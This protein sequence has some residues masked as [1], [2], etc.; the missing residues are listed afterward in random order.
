[1][2]LESITDLLSLKRWVENELKESQSHLPTHIAKGRLLSE[3]AKM[4]TSHIPFDR[5]VVKIKA[6]VREIKTRFIRQWEHYQETQKAIRI[7][8]ATR[9]FFSPA[10]RV[11]ATEEIRGIAKQLKTADASFQSQLLERLENIISSVEKLSP[12]SEKALVIRREFTQAFTEDR[13]PVIKRVRQIFAQHIYKGPRS[14]EVHWDPP[15][16]ADRAIYFHATT[17]EGIKGILESQEIRVSQ[18]RFYEGAF[19]STLPESNYGKYV[20]VLNRSI[21]F[22]APVALS[23][24]LDFG[25]PIGGAFC[26][27]GF[28]KPIPV[29]SKTLECVAVEDSTED[30]SRLQKEL[31]EIAGRE[32]KVVSLDELKFRAVERSI[33]GDVMIPKEWPS[34]E[35]FACPATPV[36]PNFAAAYPGI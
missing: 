2:S 35:N 19:V 33:Q 12:S 10:E 30:L 32:I 34:G 29:N 28:G 16:E 26:W 14:K 17:I 22:S 24:C 21:E 6:S 8:L 4:M 27:I 31:S 18:G 3:I 20:I 1:M 23:K 7:S 36:Q 13:H 11:A 25:G 5:V 15:T 9:E